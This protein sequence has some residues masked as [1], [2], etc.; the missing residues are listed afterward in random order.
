MPHAMNAAIENKLGEPSIQG[1]EI[2]TIRE[3]AR[4]KGPIPASIQGRYV[5]L[6]QECPPYQE[7]SGPVGSLL[8]H[9][10]TL[11]DVLSW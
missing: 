8:T 4:E 10:E 3:T 6:S 11:C 9:V 7:L 5:A 1:A 2:W